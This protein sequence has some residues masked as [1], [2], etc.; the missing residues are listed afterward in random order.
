[1]HPV[2]PLPKKIYKTKNRKK[3]KTPKQG[4]EVDWMGKTYWKETKNTEGINKHWCETEI[5]TKN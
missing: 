3:E 4:T 2:F 5:R 1:M